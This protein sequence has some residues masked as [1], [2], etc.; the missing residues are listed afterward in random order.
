M[1]IQLIAATFFLFS[2]VAPG[3]AAENPHGVAVIIG[4]KSYSSSVPSV[5][6]AH[7]D[8]QAFK[9]YVV[10][11][12]GFRE[13]N[14][15][16]LRDATQSKLF[17]VF[18]N[19]S[20]HEG[21]V[22]QYVRPNKSD[23]VVYYSGH[24]VP[25]QKV[26]R[27]Y[28]LPVDANPDTPEINGYPI[29]LLYKNLSKIETRSTTVFLDTC[30]SGESAKGMLINSASPIHL[31]AKLPSMTSGMTIVTA[32]QGDQLASWDNEAK[33]G[34]FTEHL[35]EAL[36]GKADAKGYGN[37]NGKITLKEI[38]SYLDE[39][40]TYAA[41]RGYGRHQQAT[42]MG[43]E[44]IVLASYSPGNPHKRKAL[45]EPKKEVAIAPVIR[46]QSD[47]TQAIRFKPG[48][49]NPKVLF[50]TERC[51]KIKLFGLKTVGD[52]I[53]GKW[54]HPKSAGHL[55]LSVKEDWLSFA[56]LGPLVG[57]SRSK[58]EINGTSVKIKMNLTHEQGSCM[59]KISLP[60]ILEK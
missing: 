50:A 3:R 45:P 41:R 58:F 28:L 49:H 22:W 27:G 21:K 40:M 43:D 14:I 55:R 56:F 17:S 8:A 5:D 2:L 31:A 29:D 59:M 54:R 7:N 13:G 12:L 34:L 42:V 48:D 44:E 30:F 20:T 60:D 23:V 47:V 19:Q 15:I 24:G 33:H 6:Y 10:D 16:D 57:S 4:N 52:K 38:K 18:G 26:Q 53:L 51:K 46:D 37:E 1:K 36:Y 35:L 32:A 39:E 9:Q 11:V 25:G